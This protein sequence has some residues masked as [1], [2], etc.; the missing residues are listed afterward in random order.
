MEPK[1]NIAAAPQV[2]EVSRDGHVLIM[3]W[4]DGE[5]MRVGS[6]ALRRGSRAAD[7]VRAAIDGTPPGA[8]VAPAIVDLQPVGTYALNI[9]F[10]DGHDRGIYPW[11]LL[12]ELAEADNGLAGGN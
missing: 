10:A 6:G 1:I 2:I 5:T 4:A 8:T 11:S 9:R 12:R 3:R 7:A